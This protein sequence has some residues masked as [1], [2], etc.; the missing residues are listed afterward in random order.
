[1]TKREFLEKFIEIE[2]FKC[3]FRLTNGTELC[4]SILEI[5][6]DTFEYFE[7]GPLAE[8]LPYF[9]SIEEIDITSFSY[10]DESQKKWIDYKPD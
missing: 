2:Q 3:S 9:L 5:L 8:D 10:Y 7:S 4:G 1:M 6:E